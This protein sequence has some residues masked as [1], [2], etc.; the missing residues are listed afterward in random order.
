MEHAEEARIPED[1]QHRVAELCLE[2]RMFTEEGMKM[3]CRHYGFSEV[4][5]EPQPLGSWRIR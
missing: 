2:K 5:T 1:E 3:L 4:T